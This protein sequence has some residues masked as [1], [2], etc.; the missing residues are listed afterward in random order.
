[1]EE[2]GENEERLK[3]E[4]VE[5]YEWNQLSFLNHTLKN[6]YWCCVEF[7]K[8]LNCKLNVKPSLR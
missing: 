3:K 6:K 2:N 5:L 4:S 8:A 7:G 1:M